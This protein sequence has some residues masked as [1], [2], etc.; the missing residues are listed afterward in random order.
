[1]CV[2]YHHDKIANPSGAVTVISSVRQ[3]GIRK[4]IPASI[5]LPTAQDRPPI[6]LKNALW[7]V[8]HHSMTGLEFEKERGKK[9]DV[10]ILFHFL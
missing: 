7:A 2:A 4:A 6:T 5:M 3:S 1:M 10:S 9:K 8:L